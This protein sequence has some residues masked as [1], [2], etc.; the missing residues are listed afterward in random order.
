MDLQSL[1]FH[2]FTS[3]DLSRDKLAFRMFK[4]FK[5]NHMKANPGKPHVLLSNKKIEKVKINHV[6]LSSSV[7]EKLLGI[8]INSELKF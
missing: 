3:F 2:F 4:W 6:A 5:N 1:A 8:T 7:E